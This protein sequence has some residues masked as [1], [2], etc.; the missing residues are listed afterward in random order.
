MAM[1]ARRARA[2][3]E[4]CPSLRTPVRRRPSQNYQAEGHGFSRD[5]SMRERWETP[6]LCTDRAPRCAEGVLE[7][8]PRRSFRPF[9]LSEESRAD[10]VLE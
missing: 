7:R 9:S 2:S 6:P 3:R 4:G 10:N 1:Q 5:S 8:P